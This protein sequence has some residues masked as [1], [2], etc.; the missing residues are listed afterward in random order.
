VNT[1][2]G[3]SMV[4]FVIVVGVVVVGG[5]AL[6]RRLVEGGNRCPACRLRIPRGATRCGHCG[7][8]LEA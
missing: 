8:D 7:Q 2:Q 4:L 3:V 6:L 1:N 5:L